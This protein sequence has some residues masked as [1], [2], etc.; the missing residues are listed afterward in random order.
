MKAELLEIR[1]HMAR[2]PPFDELDDALLDEV[3]SQVDV[4]YFKAGS[5]ILEA[6]REIHDLCYIRS[7]AV[8]IYRRNEDLYNRLGEGDIF[9][10]FNLLRNNRVRFPA[11]AMEDT[12][13][14]YIP[15]SIFYRLCEQDDRFAEF[16]EVEKPRLQSTVEAQHKRN[17]LMSTRVRKVINRLPLL[18]ESDATARDAATRMTN[19][20]VSAALIVEP[21]EDASMAIYTGADGRQWA[22]CGILTDSD[23]RQRLVAEG[24]SPEEPIAS[25]HSG[26][27]ITIQ[28]DETVQEAM[29][30]ILRNNVQHLPVLHRRRP[31]GLLHLSD[32]IRYETQSSLYLVGSILNQSSLRGLASLKHEVRTGF[33]RMVRDGS[34]SKV[35]GTALSAI[36]RSFARRILE[37]AEEELGPPP[38][39]YA[40]MVLGSMARDEQTLVTDQDNAMVLSNDYDP[41]QHGEYFATL[42]KR[43]SDGLATC[44][45][46]YCSGNIM[47]T[48]DQ[49][50]QPQKIWRR[51]FTEWIDNPTA[52]SLLHC[53]IFFDLDAVHGDER[54]VEELQDL[55]V[56]KAPLAERFLAAMARNA[57][58]R[59]PPLGF[60]R[61]FVM[62]KNGKENRSI[63]IKRRGTAP[64]V[65]LIRIHA[66]ACGSRAQNSF[67][68]L[69][70]IAQTQLLTPN[71]V[72]KIRYALEFMSMARI[73]HHL[74]D[75]EAGRE[76][77]NNIEPEN[78]SNSERHNLKDAFQ[79]LSNAQ[80][81]L[82]FRYPSPRG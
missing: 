60:F 59:T 69:D 67:D 18:I 31:V 56:N 80:S 64:M 25:L 5:M 74:Y 61:T 21:A 39:P 17:D 19:E 78:V 38:V 42:A 7:G 63:N 30:S 48:N 54:L 15:D 70:D 72:E 71:A 29:L 37:L 52:E 76:P 77:D 16:V 12:L 47:A 62:E 65:D 33:V 45:Y 34:D 79:V 51:Y 26:E 82:Q 46:A 75:V 8:E 24:R 13:I 49:W 20:N 1:D 23:L 6:D 32:I 53:N 66:L 43:V 27:L 73:W 41:E 14:Y 81:F 4:A 35:I 22:L 57:L 11:R 10:H 28:S 40:F 36:G 2:F 3:A 9:G 55:V 68:R 44:G 50:R 58:N